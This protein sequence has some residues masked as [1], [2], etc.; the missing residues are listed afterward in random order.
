[1]AP[2]PPSYAD[3]LRLT[4]SGRVLPPS[5]PSSPLNT[6]TSNPSPYNSNNPYL[7]NSNGMDI[8]PVY[9][10]TTSPMNTNPHSQP[11]SLPVQIPTPAQM[12]DYFNNSQTSNQE[13]PRGGSPISPVLEIS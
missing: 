12:Q 10:K 2:P 5:N 3:H 11:S 8:E 6:N 13:N 4:S 9:T 7:T 1:M